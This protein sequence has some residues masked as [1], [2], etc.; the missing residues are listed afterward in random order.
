LRYLFDNHEGM[1]TQRLFG[2]KEASLK[3]RRGGPERKG[4]NNKRG[5]TGIRADR[6][7]PRGTARAAGTHLN[8]KKKKERSKVQKKRGT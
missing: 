8:Y 3:K 2:K 7:R 4:N 6:K 5:T 1:W